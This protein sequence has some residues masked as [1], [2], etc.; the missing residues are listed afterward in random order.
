MYSSFRSRA[1]LVALVFALI[2]SLV[3]A[4]PISATESG[5][6]TSSSP[7][8]NPSLNGRN[9]IHHRVDTPKIS[10]ISLSGRMSTLP[11]AFRA[12]SNKVRYSLFSC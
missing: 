8:S 9:Q 7:R 2:I 10:E 1:G 5:L 6:S 11:A 4:V 12:L 3:S